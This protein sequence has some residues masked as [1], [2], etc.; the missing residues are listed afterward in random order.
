MVSKFPSSIPAD[1]W[2]RELHLITAGNAGDRRALEALYRD[3][4]PWVLALA[5]KLTGSRD[6]ALDVHQETFVYLY[7]K[8]PGFELRVPL[9]SF[10]YPVV[11][12][13]SISLLRRHRRPIDVIEYRS[14]Y[15]R[16]VSAQPRGRDFERLTAGLPSGQRDVIVL[17]YGLGLRLGEIARVRGIPLGT[18]KSRLHSALKSLRSEH[19]PSADRS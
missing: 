5:G 14:M 2:R 4:S 13:R 10:L 16:T 17:R 9:R 15:P 19:V 18:V 3:H 1:Q 12:H 8:F 7:S 6:D 11:K